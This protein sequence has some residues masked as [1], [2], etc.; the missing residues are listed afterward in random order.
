[1]S[2]TCSRY[3]ELGMILDKIKGLIC[4]AGNRSYFK[5]EHKE[6]HTS[7][8]G[9][10]FHNYI[11]IPRML[12]FCLL[13]AVS[14]I[15][16]EERLG[17][18]LSYETYTKMF[19]KRIMDTSVYYRKYTKAFFIKNLSTVIS[20]SVHWWSTSQDTCPTLKHSS[21]HHFKYKMDWTPQQT[22]PTRWCCSYANS[23]HHGPHRHIAGPHSR[24]IP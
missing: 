7:S 5:G 4:Q 3:K 18:S 11:Y 24:R 12:L 2:I 14:K 16:L 1:M 15:L 19:V 8:L 10:Q 22:S 17:I 13:D 21:G 20:A 6:V 9:E 23:R